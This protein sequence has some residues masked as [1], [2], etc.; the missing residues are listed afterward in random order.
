MNRRVLFVVAWLTFFCAA[1]LHATT[2]YIRKDGGTRNSP[3]ARNGQCN[4]RFDAAYPGHGVNQHC[5]FSDFRYL[6]DDQ[7][8]NS[9][10]WVIA[11]GDT[12]IIEG[13]SPSSLQQ[14]PHGTDCRIGWD[15]PAGTGAGY[16]WC[17]GGG[18]YGLSSYGCYNSPIP[19]GTAA[20]HTR[21][22]GANYQNCSLNNQP[23][24][25][26]MA[27][28]FGG[29]STNYT[30]SLA[31]TQYVDVECVHITSHNG[32]CTV[33]GSPS[34]PR[35]CATSYPV[36]D[37]DA[38]G[39]QVDPT[40][41]NVTLQDVAIDGHT[42]SGI[43]GPIGANFTMNRVFVGF[44]G[45]AGWNFD[46][47]HDTPN[48]TGSSINASYVTME[49]NGCYQQW[50]IA[51][52]Q[53]P[54]RACYDDVSGG[55]GDSWSG[56]D[57]SLTSFTCNH[58]KQIYNTKDGFIGPHT[59][60]TTLLIENSESIGNMG[61]QWKWNNTPNA[62]TVF[63]NNIAVGDCGRMSDPLPGAAHSFGKASKQSG[64]YLSDFCRAAG[65]TLSFSSRENS[66]VLIAGNTIVSNAPTVIDI[67]CGPAG[68]KAG[69][70]G[71][72]PFVFRDNVFL[73]YTPANGEAPGLFY[74]ADHSVRITSSNN[75]E[76]GIRNGDSCGRSILCS[77]PMFSVAPPRGWTGGRE[78][79]FLDLTPRA[80]SPVVGA[81]VAVGG[82]TKDYFG[83]RRPVHPSLGALE[84][85][86]PNGAGSKR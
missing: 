44:N 56:Q 1:S 9:N 62:T 82:L 81:G 38:S 76:Y 6:W 49:G 86:S 66:N 51:N 69:T 79:D 83:N 34:Y 59:Q 77:D 30:L 33:H 4:G 27:V 12:V 74:R 58:C 70:C 21:I 25:T 3:T 28:L 24:P 40:T 32:V 8:M 20:Q 80:A 54:A 52:P 13:C 53:F 39:V 45:F 10:A 17:K 35:G 78:L 67:D 55:F 36:D 31:E 16:T 63:E 48:G 43:S 42:T 7:S 68:G 60:I 29:W 61:Q 22:L 5:A 14:N 23:D 71:S 64:A 46:D 37:F 57:S 72:T 73:G 11:G 15:A 50:P 85:G 84:P 41:A 65:D 2:W 19:A 18:P 26:K 47:G 75:L